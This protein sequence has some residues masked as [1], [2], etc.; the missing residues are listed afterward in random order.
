MIWETS[1]AKGE[2]QRL[3][4]F[5]FICA[6]LCHSLDFVCVRGGQLL[7]CSVAHAFLH[8]KSG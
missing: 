8:V 7:M 2:R 6:I 1:T 5:S 4:D 3:R